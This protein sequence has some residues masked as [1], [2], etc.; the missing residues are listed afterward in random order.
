MPRSG[1]AAGRG[2]A[3]GPETDAR[4]YVHQSGSPSRLLLPAEKVHQPAIDVGGEPDSRANPGIDATLVML[5]YVNG[6]D[7]YV[8]PEKLCIS[9]MLSKESPFTS[10]KLTV[11]LL[12]VVG[13]TDV[14]VRLYTTLADAG[15]DSAAPTSKPRSEFLIVITQSP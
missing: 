13:N 14:A 5:V 7:R 15:D 2:I 6:R 3:G 1:S 11:K 8:I 10:S 4:E 9:P 12:K